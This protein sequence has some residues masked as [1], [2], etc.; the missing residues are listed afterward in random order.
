MNR[1][2]K[3][4]RLLNYLAD[5]IIDRILSY[6]KTDSE[7]YIECKYFKVICDL[8]HN[9]ITNYLGFNFYDASHLNI[10]NF[11]IN[12]NEAVQK[13]LISKEYTQFENQ[14]INDFIIE[15]YQCVMKDGFTAPITFDMIINKDTK[16]IME[17]LDQLV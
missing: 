8:V 4:Y 11:N 12:P 2:V 16:R 6:S 17:I 3:I 5:P 13:L 7:L 10:I 15:L 1:Q 14:E 9:Q